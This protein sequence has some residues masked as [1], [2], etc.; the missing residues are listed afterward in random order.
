M[1][2][3]EEMSSVLRELTNL[4]QLCWEGIKNFP[5]LDTDKL[6][7][8]IQSVRNISEQFKKLDPPVKLKTYHQLGKDLIA[9]QISMSYTTDNLIKSGNFKYVKKLGK[10]AN[11]VSRISIFM[12]SEANKLSDDID[13]YLEQSS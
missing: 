7:T 11:K 12:T 5:N 2:Y 3:L 13:R 8:Y 10:L 9:T 1:T 6:N 4:N